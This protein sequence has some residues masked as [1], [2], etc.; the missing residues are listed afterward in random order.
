MP[1]LKAGDTVITEA[2][3]ILTF[4]A[5]Q[6]SERN[7]IPA[8]G[9][10]ARGEYY[11]WLCFAI[12]LEYAAFDRLNQIP[13]NAE[14]RKTIGYGDLDTTFGV[15]R[16]HLARYDFIVGNQFSALDIYYTMLLTQFTRVRP[17]EGIACDVFDAYI[18]RHTTRAAFGET[19]AWVEK[20]MAKMGIAQ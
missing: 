10:L 12:N 2:A 13:S 4:L 8:A 11:R 7:L 18:A 15:L 19:M 16:E 6:F 14:R 3:A 1:A 9:S 17:V 20:K 5:E